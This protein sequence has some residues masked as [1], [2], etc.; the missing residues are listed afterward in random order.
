[1]VTIVVLLILAG[2]SISTVLGGNGILTKANRAKEK[3][4]RAEV[5]EKAQMDILDIEAENKSGDIS[6]EEL[7]QILD[8]YFTDVPEEIPDDLSGGMTLTSKEEYGKQEIEIAEIWNGKFKETP[9]SETESYV[10]YYA[11]FDPNDG[12]IDGII[13][14]DLKKGNTGSSP[15]GDYND[16]GNYTIPTKETTKDYYVS[17]TNYPGAFGTKD[18]LTPMGEGNDRFYIMELE[19][20]KVG[21]NSSFCWYNAAYGKLDNTINSSENDF[22]A[23]KENTKT[24]IEEWNKGITGKYGEQNTGSRPDMWGVI[25]EK[26]RKGWFVP[27]KSEWAALG[28]ELGVTGDNHEQTFGLSDW[29]WSSSEYLTYGAWVVRFA[30]DCMANGTVGSLG[31]VRLS[32]TF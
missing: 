28:G 31:P 24:M 7:K 23:G 9:V 5:I 25:Q 26:V 32:A 19:D 27:S 17:Q 2:V 12:K 14:A 21:D 3:T 8:K 6:K 13:Y 11:D 29:Y 22:G 1:M 15:W 30:N 18:V 16:F 10:G 20:F 4:K